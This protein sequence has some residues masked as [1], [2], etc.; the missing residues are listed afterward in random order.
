MIKSYSNFLFNFYLCSDHIQKCPCKE[1]I[2]FTE[3]LS[4]EDEITAS[5]ITGRI[6]GEYAKP[7]QTFIRLADSIKV[8]NI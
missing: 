7:N 6:L 8:T 1:K 2:V 3:K 5:G 4:F